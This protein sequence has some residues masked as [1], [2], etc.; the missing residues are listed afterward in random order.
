M[1]GLTNLFISSNASCCSFPYMT[2][3]PFLVKLY[4]G[5]S[6]FCNSGQNI[7]KQLTIPVKLQQ[8]FGVVGSLNFCTVSNLLLNGLTHF[9][10]S[11]Q[12]YHSVV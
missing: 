8:P 2:C 12:V 11:V 5:L 10:I 3:L 9:T 1:G 6:N 7:L 4:I